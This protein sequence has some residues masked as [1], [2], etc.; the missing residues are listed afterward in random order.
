MRIHSYAEIGGK[1]YKDSAHNTCGFSI[2][3]DNAAYIWKYYGDG[4]AV[5]GC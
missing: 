1:T 2:C 3:L 4:T 5:M